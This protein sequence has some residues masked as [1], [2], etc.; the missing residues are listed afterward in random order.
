MIL[1]G[2]RRPAYRVRKVLRGF[3]PALSASEA[4]AV[5]ALLSEP[6][7]QLFLDM[8]ARDRR[9]AV[10]VVRWLRA[11]TDP[12]HALLAAALLHDVGKGPLRL[13]HRVAFALLEAALPPLLERIAAP[14]GARWRRALWTL[15]HHPRLGAHLLSEAGTRAEIVELVARHTER[16][17]PASA[18]AGTELAWLIVADH[19]C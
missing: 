5:R 2:L 4:T 12:S 19:A 10:D 18:A 14:R 1:S 8:E 16:A 17:A 6:E 3:R 13:W 7:L 15:R 9:H 11:H